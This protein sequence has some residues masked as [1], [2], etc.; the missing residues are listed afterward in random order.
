MV[1][2]CRIAHGREEDS[3]V[4]GVEPRRLQIELQAAQVVELQVAKVGATA[5]DQILL[6]GRQHE[7]VFTRQVAQ[8]AHGAREPPGSAVLH[9]LR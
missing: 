5:G 9:R 7:H 4:L 6:L 2:R 8:A 3:I 1:I